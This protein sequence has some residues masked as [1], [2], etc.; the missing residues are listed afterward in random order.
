MSIPTRQ[1][2]ITCLQHSVINIPRAAYFHCENADLR[3]EWIDIG[4]M[5]VLEMFAFFWSALNY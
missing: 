1:V 5:T 2:E 4:K 3:I